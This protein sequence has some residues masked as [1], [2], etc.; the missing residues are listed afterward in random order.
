LADKAKKKKNKFLNL[1]TTKCVPSGIY[2]IFIPIGHVYYNRTVGR[3][4]Y[5][6]MECFFFITPFAF[7][8][9]KNTL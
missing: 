4:G 7:H 5:F 3:Y 8:Q 9:T 6:Q 2:G 1:L